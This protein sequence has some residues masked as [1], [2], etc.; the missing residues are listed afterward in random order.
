MGFAAKIWLR[1]A[2][3]QDLAQNGCFPMIP[4]GIVNCRQNAKVW[5][6]KAPGPALASKGRFPMI[7]EANY[8]SQLADAKLPKSGSKRLLARI[9]PTKAI[10]QC[11]L[12]VTL[13]TAGPVEG[14]RPP[15]I[16]HWASA[17]KAAASE[18]KALPGG[19][20]QNTCLRSRSG[21]RARS[22]AGD[23][24]ISATKCLLSK[25]QRLKKAKSFK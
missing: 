15:P 7:S 5:L 19:I 10:S 4:E 3:G 6:L 13:G 25:L 1:K 20:F 12:S 18:P 24:P 17:F 2:P 8:N 23:L 9:W 16:R 21:Q 14:R 11:L 22:R